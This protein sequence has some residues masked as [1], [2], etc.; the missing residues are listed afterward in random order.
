M[1]L[2]AAHNSHLLTL[3]WHIKHVLNRK[4]EFKVPI[5]DLTNGSNPA[6]PVFIISCRELECFA[7]GGHLKT[8]YF[9]YFFVSCLNDTAISNVDDLVW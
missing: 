6:F 4:F 5:T 9:H 8:A 2:I 1:T 3:F 7:I